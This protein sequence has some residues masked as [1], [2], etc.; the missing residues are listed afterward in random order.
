ML[1]RKNLPNWERWLRVIAGVALIAYALIGTSSLL[2]MGLVLASA[3]VVVV[4][5]FVGFCPACAMVGRK[6]VN[7]DSRK[8]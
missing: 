7:P 1:Y 6:L 8:D 5:G 3:L 4:T 2:I